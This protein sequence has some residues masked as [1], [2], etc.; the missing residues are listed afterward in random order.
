MKVAKNQTTKHFLVF[1]AFSIDVTERVL[2]RH[3]KPVSL[4]PKA[5]DTL[6]ALV[7]NTGRVL[8]KDELMKTVWPDTVVEE[9]NLTQAISALLKAFGEDR[10]ASSYIETLPR[11]GYRFV[12]EVTEREEEIPAL[13]RKGRREE[14]RLAEIGVPSTEA[15]VSAD[16]EAPARPAETIEARPVPGRW[17]TLKLAMLAAALLAVTV[18]AVYYFWLNRQSTNRLGGGFKHRRSVAVL[19]LKNLSERP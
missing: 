11:R 2:N 12:A 13:Y 14:G 16:R 5:F 15:P 6:L 4:T 17:I 10:A 7:E 8:D 1:G 19:G 18:F 3:G 9:N